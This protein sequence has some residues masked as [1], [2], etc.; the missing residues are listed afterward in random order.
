MIVGFVVI[1][2]CG[3]RNALPGS[4]VVDDD[5]NAN[6]NSINTGPASAVATSGGPP[7]VTH[8]GSQAVTVAGPVTTGGS[9]VAGPTSG[10]TGVTTGMIP[11][12][13]TDG[14]SIG[15]GG[16]PSC[17]PDSIGGGQGGEGGAPSELEQC[18]IPYCDGWA[19]RDAN[20]ADIQGSFYLFHD[21]ESGGGS[22]IYAAPGTGGNQICVDGHVNQVFD[23]RY[24]V[25]WGAGFGMS[26]NQPAI[27]RPPEPYDAEAASVVGFGFHVDTLPYGELRFTVRGDD[28]Y[29]TQV[30][31]SGYSEY[32][33]ADLIKGCWEP[34]TTPPDYSGLM[35]IEWHLVANAQSSY[36]FSVCMNN[37]TVY[38]GPG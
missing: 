35:S 16:S 27:D 22:T 36:S 30:L 12:T 10:F 24:D 1:G 6:T 18:P 4:L 25:Y 28:F 11:A 15:V 29:C 21:Q 13:T 14:G 31:T 3:S 23:S 20:C 33:L 37:L 34:N 38:R 26:L 32:M 9:F 19:P 17:Y 2:A 7:G 5:T 8:T